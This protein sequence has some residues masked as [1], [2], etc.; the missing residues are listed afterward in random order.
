M[1]AIDCAVKRTRPVTSSPQSSKASQNWPKTDPNVNSDTSWGLS[2]EKPV[3][4]NS[5]AV[6]WPHVESPLLHIAHG[7]PVAGPKVLE[8]LKPS[9]QSH[10]VGSCGCGVTWINERAIGIGDALGV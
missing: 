9:Y 8:A 7:A 2:I 1:L 10:G 3:M 6:Q 5:G 4:P